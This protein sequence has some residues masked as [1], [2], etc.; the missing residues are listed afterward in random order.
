MRLAPGGHSARVGQFDL[1]FEHLEVLLAVE[2]DL[3]VLGIDLDVLADDG[4]QIA[5][6]VGLLIHKKAVTIRRTI[7]S[8]P[9][10]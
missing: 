7:K 2:L 4:D 6:Q 8:A 3:D 1:D 9:T 5:L 10:I